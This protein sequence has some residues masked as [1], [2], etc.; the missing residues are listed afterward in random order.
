MLDYHQHNNEQPSLYDYLLIFW[1]GNYFGK[2][3][4]FQNYHLPK[5][6]F[7]LVYGE[8]RKFIDTLTTKVCC[9]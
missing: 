6:G 8:F 3:L 5:A 1:K 4:I 2:S 7:T 9:M